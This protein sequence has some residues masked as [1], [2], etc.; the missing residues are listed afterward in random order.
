MN[1]GVSRS[2]FIT[3]LSFS[4]RAILI[5]AFSP[6]GIA[7]KISQHEYYESAKTMKSVPHVVPVNQN[8][9]ALTKRP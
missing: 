8:I 2:L 6:V 1:F 3:S 4:L 9:T 7:V 5:Q